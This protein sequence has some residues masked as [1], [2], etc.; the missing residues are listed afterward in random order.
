MKPCSALI[1]SGGKSSRMKTDKASLPFRGSSFLKHAVEQLSFC[2]DLMLSTACESDYPE[3]DIPHVAD[4]YPGC[5]PMAGICSGLAAA[6]N[7]WLFAVACDMPF[8]EADLAEKLFEA[9]SKLDDSRVF[10]AIVPLSPNGRMEPLC[11][12]YHKRLL[13]VFEQS[14]K[15]GCFGLQKVLRQQRIVCIPFDQLH[16][17]PSVF[18]NI[19]TKADYEEIL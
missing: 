9:A 7:E 1:L 18:R 19:N 11:A 16:L 10:D 13:P 5:G 6:K 17:D 4:Q 3:I 8:F 14:L 2:G 12:L 15:D